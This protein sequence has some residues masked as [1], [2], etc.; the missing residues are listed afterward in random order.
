MRK[1]RASENLV[2]QPVGNSWSD[3]GTLKL[4]CFWYREDFLIAGK[5]WVRHSQFLLLC[6][7]GIYKTNIDC[8]IC[9]FV[10][11]T[12]ASNCFPSTCV[13]TAAW[14]SLKA[15]MGRPHLGVPAETGSF[16][17]STK[18]GREFPEQWNRSLV[19]LLLQEALKCEVQICTTRYNYILE[20][21]VPAHLLS[22]KV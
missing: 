14:C 8:M 17:K 9:A 16:G 12:V 13:W 1:N 19:K 20:E 22:C 3:L 11:S 10:A 15:E 7:Q 18:T 5:T 2:L 4:P 6:T 21:E